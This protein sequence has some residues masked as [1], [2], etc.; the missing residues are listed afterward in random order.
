MLSTEF[1]EID[2]YI[3]AFNLEMRLA[4]WTRGEITHCIGSVS[5]FIIICQQANA[6][7][8]MA[9]AH[10][11]QSEAD[12]QFVYDSI[13][14]WAIKLDVDRQLIDLIAIAAEHSPQDFTQ[15]QGWVCIA[16]QNA[17]WQLL[18]APSLQTGITDTVMR[19]GDTDTNAAICG[20]LLGAVYGIDQVPDQWL[21]CILNCKP[22]PHNPNVQHPRPQKYWPCDA[23]ELVTQLIGV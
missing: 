13:C 5:L 11:I 12:K 10:A 8:A 1:Q 15:Q 20:A 16:F 23:F 18:H 22:E 19:G 4:F 14:G 21:K 3:F 6:L 2:R 17:L 7:Y 9:I